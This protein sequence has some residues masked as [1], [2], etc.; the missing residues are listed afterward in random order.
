M[1][2]VCAAV[3][4]QR[5]QGRLK[6][7]NYPTTVCGG[8]VLLKAK[9]KVDSLNHHAERVLRN[10]PVSC[11]SKYDLCT[12]SIASLESLLKMP[13]PLR[14]GSKSTFSKLPGDLLEV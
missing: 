14:T 10:H 1:G 11:Y 6:F 8:A 7:L 13:H 5:K 2:R 3:V 12:S 4:R 9:A